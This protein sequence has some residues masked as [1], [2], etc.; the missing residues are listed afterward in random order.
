MCKCCATR[1]WLPH[2]ATGVG[3]ESKRGNKPSPN[4]CHMTPVIYRETRGFVFIENTSEG[5]GN[6][7]NKKSPSPDLLPFSP[8]TFPPSEGTR[9][10]AP[11]SA[12][13][14]VSGRRP[15]TEP[16]PRGSA[17]RRL[18]AGEGEA[19]GP[20]PGP[21]ERCLHGPG[22]PSPAP[23]GAARGAGGGRGGGSGGKAPFG[24]RRYEHKSPAFTKAPQPLCT[25][26]YHSYIFMV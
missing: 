13:T 8:K 25:A 7:N 12:L 9:C 19:A 2:G 22:G 14:R 1:S 18:P 20:G 15:R 10:S 3:G 4:E 17:H 24:S 6:N 11:S 23:V 21:G 16:A 26:G 5:G